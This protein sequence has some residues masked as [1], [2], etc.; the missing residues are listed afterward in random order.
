MLDSK[1]RKFA[2][3]LVW[4]DTKNSIKNVDEP[5][6]WYSLGMLAVVKKNRAWDLQGFILDVNML[7]CIFWALIFIR[8]GAVVR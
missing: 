8:G 3:L 7:A 1:N 6:K 2:F 4:V 5:N